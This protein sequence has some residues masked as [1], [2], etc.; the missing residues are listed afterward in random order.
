MALAPL[1]YTIWNEVLL[2]ANYFNDVNLLL[3]SYNTGDSQIMIRR[4]NQERC[5]R[6]PRS[7]ASTTTPIW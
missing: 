2:F 3:S 7:C 5:A 1:V 6:S 4:D